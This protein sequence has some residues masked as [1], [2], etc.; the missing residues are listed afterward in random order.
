MRLYQEQYLANMERIAGL[1]TQEGESEATPEEFAARLEREEQE[2]REIVG[3]NMA[4]L[5]QELFPALDSAAALD[6]AARQELRDFAAGL[7][8]VPGEPDATLFCQIHQVLLGLARYWRDLDAEIQELYWLGIGRHAISTRLVGLDF[9]VVEPYTQQM[10][11]RFSE[12]ASY[13]KDFAHIED[14]ETRGYILRSLANTALGQFPSVSQRVQ[15]IK[16]A[17]QIMQDPEYRRIAPELP[18]DK[19]VQ[20]THRLMTASISYCK[21]A[22][23]SPQDV[24]DIMES[25]YIVYHEHDQAVRTQEEQRDLRHAFHYDAIEYYCGMDSLTGLLTKMERL[26]SSASADDFSNGGMYAA[27]SLPAFYSQYL[28]YYPELIAG[29]EPY[30]AGLY[31]RVLRYMDGIPPGERRDTLFFYLRQLSYTF[32]E[33][34]HGVPFSEFLHRM[35]SR[36]APEIYVHSQMVGRA[37]A[38]LCGRIFD[39]EPAFFDGVASVAAAGGREAKREEL[40]RFALEC[41]ALHDVGK[42]NFVGLY[43]GRGRQWF[44]EEYQMSRLHPVTGSTLL[45]T[46]PSTRCYADVALG[47]HAWYNHSKG[48]PSAYRREACPARRLVDVIALVDWLENA[49]H[50]AQCCTGI[51]LTLEEAVAKA[52]ELEGTRFAPRVVGCL[53]QEGVPELLWEA[54][55][56][57]KREAYGQMYARR[58]GQ[59]APNR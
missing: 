33:T 51:S 7:L 56:Q 31:R 45:T 1:T 46:R 24:A 54:F 38:A 23:M 8:K 52:L 59:H 47:H 14:S 55:A 35:M 37:A 36:F 6:E 10:R 19:F 18:W 40:A 42:V 41:G 11:R 50:S 28:G 27:I 29:R 26:M 4:L 58:K 17:L 13:L 2:K 25:V 30:L 39:K 53:R 32:V 20:Q 57:G 22:A 9:A 44:E 48:Y 5:R 15:L 34:P 43:S 12:A 21:E 49:T 3:E 16:S